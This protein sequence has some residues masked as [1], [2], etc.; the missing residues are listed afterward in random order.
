MSNVISP[1]PFEIDAW[2]ALRSEP[3]PVSFVFVTV[4]TKPLGPAPATVG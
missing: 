4:C 3:L 2:I 1:L